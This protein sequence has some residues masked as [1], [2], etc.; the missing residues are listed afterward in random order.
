MPSF[1]VRAQMER[2]HCNAHDS[3]TKFS[4]PNNPDLSTTPAMEWE[5][6]VYFDPTRDYAGGD[7]RVGGTVHF[8]FSDWRAKKAFLTEMEIIA[9]RLYR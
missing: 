3:H 8:F 7:S 2:E 6:V 1:N 5:F 9:L 4:P